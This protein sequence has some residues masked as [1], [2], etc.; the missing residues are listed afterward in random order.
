MVPCRLRRI[1][2]N[3]LIRKAC[4]TA[5]ITLGKPTFLDPWSFFSSSKRVVLMKPVRRPSS[6]DRLWRVWHGAST[7]RKWMRI[8]EL[9]NCPPV[10][11]SGRARCYLD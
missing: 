7:T 9:K 8:N 1:P 6:K 3:A 5:F 10:L 2:S 11:D 4:V